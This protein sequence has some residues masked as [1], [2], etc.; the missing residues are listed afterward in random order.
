MVIACAWGA[1][2]AGCSDAD[3]PREPETSSSGDLGTAS[4]AVPEVHTA[5]P[6][7]TPE[8]DAVRDLSDPAAGIV[9]T[10]LPDVTGP[11]AAAV[12]AYMTFEVLAWTALTTNVVPVELDSI[13]SMTV[14]SDVTARV[15]AQVASGAVRGGTQTT[16]PRVDLVEADRVSLSACTTEADVEIIYPDRVNMVPEGVS[17]TYR[18]TAEL[19][20]H[21]TAWVVASHDVVTEVC[22][23]GEVA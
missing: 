8:V 9:F 22:S 19:A 13:A 16:S 2:A 12:N 20:L 15:D 18:A 17:P 4:P 11:E 10:D 5:E 1:L 23:V 6:T 21:G 14:V 3:E 7:P